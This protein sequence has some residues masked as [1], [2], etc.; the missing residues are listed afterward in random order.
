VGIQTEQ[1]STK[2]GRKIQKNNSKSP[3]SDLKKIVATFTV[4]TQTRLVGEVKTV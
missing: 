1:F 3:R 4:S 2:A